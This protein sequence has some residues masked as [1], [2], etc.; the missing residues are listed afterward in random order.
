[1][2]IKYNL[3]VGMWIA[4]SVLSWGKLT[5]QTTTGST[6]LKQTTEQVQK[7]TIDTLVNSDTLDHSIIKKMHMS[8][9]LDEYWEEKWWEII[10]DHLLVEINDMRSI[11]HLAPVVFN[12]TLNIAAQ[13]YAEYCVEHN[14]ISHFD[15][16][17]KTHQD[18]V[19]K[20]WYT[21]KVS[22]NISVSVN[23]SIE[24]IVYDW[25]NNWSPWHR[26]NILYGTEE[27]IGTGGWRN[28]ES[29]K[30][31]IILLVD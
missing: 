1:M 19:E 14:H 27:Y 12:D 17:K 18:R 7:D 22:E 25:L 29:K 11:Y 26:N 5:G 20:H 2:S 16:E 15:L 23:T 10:K 28:K 24:H 13:E 3:A 21:R 31:R 30:I 6:P 4:L 8:D 9:I